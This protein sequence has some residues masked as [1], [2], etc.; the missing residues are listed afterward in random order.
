MEEFG[1]YL[2]ADPKTGERAFERDKA[3][4]IELG[5]PLRWISPEGAEEDDGLG[6]Y[7]IDR[8]HYYLPHLELT[9]SELA[10]L[11]IAGAAAAAVDGLPGQKAML[12]AL[13]KLGFDVGE[14]ETPG[15]MMLA[16]APLRPSADGPVVSAFLERLYD[17]VVQKSRVVMV[18][19]GSSTRVEREVDP[20][21]LY[22][23]QGSWYLVGYCHHRGGERTFHV[24]RIKELSQ[25]TGSRRG[26]HFE[27]P[28]T[29]DLEVH[30]RRRPWEYPRETPIEV[31]LRL[32]TRLVPAVPEIFGGRA[33]IVMR[34]EDAL[35]YVPVSYP[36]PFINAILPF[37]SAIE[38]LEPRVLR[39]R[40][41]DIFRELSVV[42]G[43]E[44]A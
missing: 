2:S 14:S 20:Y 35:V 26:G 29:F 41:G 10:L 32:A 40:V 21:G 31:K 5:V 30:I 23:R 33:R 1:A 39:R 42:Y 17:S 12:R 7:S 27:L 34:D 6:G 43:G 11:S 38:V 37:G 28:E 15:A 9:A 16:H 19:A 3:S 13:A 18:Y 22:Y 36:E 24:G 4:L 44:T 25:A 8:E